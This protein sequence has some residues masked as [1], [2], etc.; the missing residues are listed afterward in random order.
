[1]EIKLTD[2]SINARTAAEILGVPVETFRTW[3]KRHD[4]LPQPVW[5]G[6]GRAPEMTF[7][8]RHLLQA[9][10]AQKLMSVGV[11][12]GQA[13]KA[14]HYGVFHD[15]MNQKEVRIGFVGGKIHPAPNE[16]EDVFLTFLLE[17][18]GASIARKLADDISLSHGNE[19]G[20]RALQNF[21]KAVKN[22]RSGNQP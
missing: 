12:V 17:N 19:V 3:R 5:G 22:I 4:F 18:D 14:V 8:F 10:A 13:C 2:W 20:E 11:P 7:Q 1:M 6:T 21:W 15:F 16:Y 9:K